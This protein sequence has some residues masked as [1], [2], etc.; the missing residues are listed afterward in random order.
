MRQL[1]APQ[2][3]VQQH[4]VHEQRGRPDTLLRVADAARRGV[5][6]AA[7]GWRSDPV[8]GSA[9]PRRRRGGMCLV[10]P[11]RTFAA[12]HLDRLAADRDLDRVRIQLAVASRASFLGHHTSLRECPGTGRRE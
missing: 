1:M 8:Y 10:Q 11:L 5:D 9:L 3:S 6:A 2:M 12:A 4:T 7:N